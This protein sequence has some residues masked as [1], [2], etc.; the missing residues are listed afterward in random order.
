VFAEIPAN[1]NIVCLAR[2]DTVHEPRHVDFAA[3]RIRFAWGPR[4]NA[5]GGDPRHRSAERWL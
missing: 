1:G 5:G 3:G 2:P 4:G